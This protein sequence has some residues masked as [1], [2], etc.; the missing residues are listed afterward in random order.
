MSGLDGLWIALGVA[1]LV[2]TFVD[3]FL[4][5]LNYNEPGIIVNRLVRLQW[6]LLR[7][8]TR[9]VSRRWR[10]VVLR[11]I[12]GILLLSTILWWIGGVVL[13]F[14]FIYLGL[15]G[16][17]A[18]QI[19]SGVVPDFVGALYLSV[20]QFATVGADNISPG[21]GWVNLVPVLEA[22]LSVVLLSFIITFLGNIYGVIQALRSLC[23]DFFSAGP[24]VGDPVDALRPYFP[25]GA[26][27]DLDRHLNELVDDFNLYCDS[28]RQDHAAYHFQ[29]GEDQFAL[30]FA[31]YMTSGV[32][33]ALRWGLPAD[34]IAALSPSLPRLV[35]VFDDFREL[36]YRMMKW[37]TPVLPTTVTIER[38]RADFAGFAA[39]SSRSSMDPWVV[40]FLTL[41]E[42]M[43]AIVAPAG[44]PAPAADEAYERYTR[45]LAFAYPALHFVTQVSRDLDYQPIYR[46]VGPAPDDTDVVPRGPADAGTPTGAASGARAGRSG[47]SLR[48]WLRRRHLLV[49]PGFTRLSAALRTLGAVVVAVA[50]ATTGSVA[51]HVDPIPVGV[52][53][54][55]IAVFSMPMTSGWG[56][57]RQRTAG[58][59]ALFPA[60][61]GMV[62]GAL[63]PREPV[64]SAVLL[65]VV[66]VAAVLLGRFG[67][68]CAMWGQVGFMAYYFSLL[69]A[70][71]P[72]DLVAALI[73]GG[74][75]VLSS[76]TTN[77]V[78]RSRSGREVQTGIGVVVERAV[79]LVDAATDAVSGG[80]GGRPGRV[81][82]AESAALRTSVMAL[83]SVVGPDAVGGVVAESALRRRVQAFDVQLAAENLV[84]SL[85]ADDDDT[86]SVA[87]R[88]VLAGQLAALA[89]HV[90]MIGRGTVSRLEEPPSSEVPA[91]S[92]G[93][94]RVRDAR[95]ELAHAIEALTSPTAAPGDADATD[96]SIRPVA[97]GRRPARS[98]AELRAIDR[99][100]VQAGLATGIALFLA[101]FVSTTHQYWAAMPAY[102]ALNGSD[103]ERLTR[104]IQ[105]VVGAVVGAA[106]AFGIALATGHEGLVALVVVVVSVFFMSYLRPIASAWTAFWQT[107]LLAT[108]YDS[109]ARLTAEAIHVRILETLI[110]ALVA[111]LVA[112]VILPT[113]TRARVLNGMAAVLTTSAGIVHNSL[114]AR[115]DPDST[116]R[117]ERRRAIADAESALQSHLDDVLAHA[118]PLRRDP[119]AQQRSGIESQLTSLMALAFYTRGLVRSEGESPALTGTMDARRWQL[120]AAATRDNFASA[121]AVLDERLPPRI[122]DLSDLGIA[123]ADPQSP[124][125]VSVARI[126]ET[127]LAFM[128]DVRPGSADVSSNTAKT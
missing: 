109:L 108:L 40:R 16:M 75:G 128:G 3:I 118:G 87:E 35:E 70:V 117:A 26:P 95:D 4:A 19:A 99:R 90:R 116:A 94:R 29:S 43:A 114:E 25:D 6:L 12:T 2:V 13:G 92:A 15:I 68:R 122:H 9:R 47:S 69:L 56:S 39:Q 123:D 63:S 34:S 83:T 127:L 106:L 50:V 115:A 17:G 88:S 110:G 31:L 33:G 37:P 45:W 28:L 57:G 64:T 62:G 81:L 23:A 125:L 102:L 113:R 24:G 104:T 1:I 27:R 89:H 59:L 58:L 93:G 91:S 14:T 8:I 120:L 49:D 71:T 112:A 124:S 105:R 67:P 73:A 77:L 42:E 38:F 119:G 60:A 11:Q 74:I 80:V 32:T 98:A 55:L 46:G 126:N 48:A 61:I 82:R 78:P 111:V 53:A 41:N 121:L 97:S 52:F 107:V 79:L 103:G 30:P 85:P 65:A 5:V 10:P 84:R 96:S 7:S 66:A 20:G 86:V 18:F 44:A 21:G 101:S 22:L 36:R 72:T 51:L 54:A 76:W 100:A